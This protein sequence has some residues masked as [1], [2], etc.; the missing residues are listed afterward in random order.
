MGLILL[1]GTF[2]LGAAGLVSDLV[3]LGDPPAFF[4]A[5]V[6]LGIAAV[7]VALD[8]HWRA[9]GEF[10]HGREIWFGRGLIAL[11]IV[12]EAVGFALAVVDSP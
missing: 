9:P 12:L 11:A 1:V 7:A 2:G 10:G 3:N 6:V 8:E 5:A 4:G